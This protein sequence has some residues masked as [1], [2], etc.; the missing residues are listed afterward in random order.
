MKYFRASFVIVLVILFSASYSQNKKKSEIKKIPVTDTIVK[1][2]ELMNKIPGLWSGP[3]V[4][5]TPAGSFP[6]WY[7]DFR[8]VGISQV[9][10]ISELDTI[11]RNFMSFL[12]I[13]YNG[14]RVLAFRNGGGFKGA[15]RIAYEV[16]D[17]VYEDR[18]HSLYRFSDFK[19]GKK[20][21]FTLMDFKGDSLIMQVYTNKYN[22]LDKPVRHMIWRAK[23]VDANTPKEAIKAFDYPQMIALKDFTEDFKPKPESVYFALSEDPYNEASQPYSGKA[24]INISFARGYDT[25]PGNELI[26]L[27][28][29]KPLF[30]GIVYKKDNLKYSS[31]SCHITADYNTYIFNNLHPGSYYLYAFY[32]YNGNN[33]IDKGDYM[34]SN[35]N[36]V[37]SIGERQ[38]VPA[39]V[40]LNFEIP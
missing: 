10:G 5:S 17:S 13:D 39:N 34:N 29:T 32:D 18:F 37:I 7:V 35:V 31:R 33:I 30:D 27:L 21:V 19:A 28:T 1:G 11:T 12:V 26:L 16:L 14:K 3:V 38:N 22:T 4:S 9:S 2:F 23:L 24:Q 20:R 15:N 36:Q 6:V 25:K 40:V 8:P